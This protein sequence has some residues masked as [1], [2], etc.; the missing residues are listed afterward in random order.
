MDQFDQAGELTG[1][2]AGRTPWPR[3]KMWPR[4]PATARTARACSAENGPGGEAGGGVEVAL[5][6]Y[7][8]TDP[9]AGL[10]QRYPPV[11]AYD[12]GARPGEVGQ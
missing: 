6:T 7:A 9:P 5:H 8:G 3:L 4:R 1:S 2:V 12:V 11:D 10:V